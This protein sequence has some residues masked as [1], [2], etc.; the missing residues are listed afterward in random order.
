MTVRFVLLANFVIH[1]F[2]AATLSTASAD[3]GSQALAAAGTHYKDGEYAQAVNYYREAISNGY[4]NGHVYYNLG[5]SY[6]RLGEFG[7]AIAQYRRALEL[8]PSDPD[9]L[10]NLE[11]TRR[12]A[13]DR[14]EDDNGVWSDLRRVLYFRT[15]FSEYQM[16]LGFLFLYGGFWLAVV[17]FPRRDPSLRKFALRGFGAIVLFWSLLTFGTRSNRVGEPSFALTSAARAVK[18]AVVVSDEAKIFSGNAESFQV[19]FMLHMGAEV[20]ASELRDDWVELLLPNRRR[21]W[22]KKEDVEIL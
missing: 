13:M 7:R 17:L 22:I 3:V 14:I 19:I 12:E 11:L 4:A 6:Y 18:P 10:A 5:N 20:E 21:G 2:L 8:L 9:A 16:Q 15:L 1:C